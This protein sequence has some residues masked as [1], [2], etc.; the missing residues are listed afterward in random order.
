MHSLDLTDMVLVLNV[1]LEY[2]LGT[3]AASR[4]DIVLFICFYTGLRQHSTFIFHYRGRH[5]QQ[6]QQY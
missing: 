2:R 4:P 1:I 3:E 5:Q 6:Q